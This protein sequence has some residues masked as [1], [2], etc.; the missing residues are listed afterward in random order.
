MLAVG[1]GSAEFS[2][3]L[4]GMEDMVQIACFNSPQSVTLSGTLDALEQVKKSLVEDHHLIRLLKVNLAYHSKFMAE[5]GDY[6]EELLLQDYE[7][8]PFKNEHLKMFSS[9][10]G[11]ELNQQ[12]DASYWK[13]NMVC[14]VRF[15]DA[16]QKLVFGREGAKFL[17][18]IGSSGALAGPIGQIKKALSGNDAKIQ[19]LSLFQRP[20]LRQFAFQ[21]GRSNFHLR[22]DGQLKK[23]ESRGCTC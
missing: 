8:K 5:I 14:P 13:G 17:I 2:K 21:N 1:L 18:E 15:D 22:G 4:Q 11:E 16:V 20:R 3:Y 10:T 23:S 7:S 12:A 19:Y 6:Y 9:V